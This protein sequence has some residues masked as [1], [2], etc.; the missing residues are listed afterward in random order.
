M[1]VMKVQFTLR[2]PAD[3]H[4]K[5]RKIAEQD[6]RSLTNYIEHLAKREIAAFEQENGVILLKDED[7]V[8]E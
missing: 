2:L 3:I 4:A 1:A 6:S 5:L 7:L 8:L